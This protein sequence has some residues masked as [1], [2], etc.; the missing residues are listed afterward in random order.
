MAISVNWI[1][2][3]ITVPKA[4]T[5]LI[6]ASPELRALDT[7]QFWLDLKDLEKSVD[8]IPWPDTQQNFPSYTIQGIVYAQAFRIIPPYFVTFEDGQ[9]GVTLDGTNNNILEV[10]TQNQVRLS[11]SNSAGLQYVGQTGLSPTEQTQLAEIHGQTRRGIYVDTELLVNGNGYQQTPYN[12]WTDAV[13]DAE[14][15]GL[16]EL[17]LLADAT[18]DRQLKNFEINGIG[19][20]QLDLNGQIFDGTVIR[21][22]NVTGTQGGTGSVIMF[23]CQLSN[24]VDFNGAASLVGGAGTIAFRNGGSSVLNQLVQFTAAPVTLSLTAGGAAAN[25]EISNAS[26]EYIISNVDNAGDLLHM[27]MDHGDVTIDASCTA[28][29]IHISGSARVVDNSAGAT[30]DLESLDTTL[31]FARVIENNE[32][33]EQMLRLM[34]ADAAGKIVQAGDG[35][36][37]IRDAA[38]TKDRIVGDDSANGGRDITSTDGT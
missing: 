21:L 32:S 20:P 4:D 16:R 30:V 35:S 11:S 28:G 24:V 9:Y 3:E 1:T 22:C 26:G 5:T 15:N 34:R 6:Q 13:D 38:D 33:F 10:S 25:V 36:Y 37:A 12:N 14:L 7:Q 27:H 19:L 8:G 31:V 17:F 18:V 2:G 23:D 29:T